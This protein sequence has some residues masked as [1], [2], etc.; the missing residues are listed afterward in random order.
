[1]CKALRYK[2][3]RDDDPGALEGIPSKMTKVRRRLCGIFL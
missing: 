1:V 3:R 2:I